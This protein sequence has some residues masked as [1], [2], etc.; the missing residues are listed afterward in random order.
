MSPGRQSLVLISQHEHASLQLRN[1]L[2]ERSK[3]D[4][5]RLIR[6]I[7]CEVLDAIPRGRARAVS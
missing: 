5:L 4:L 2:D 6:Q 7:G 3:L 1:L